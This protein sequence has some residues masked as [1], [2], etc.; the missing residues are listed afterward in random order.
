MP[1]IMVR[2]KARRMVSVQAFMSDRRMVA[3]D[4]RPDQVCAMFSP[5]QRDRSEI[6]DSAIMPCVFRKARVSGVV[7]APRFLTASQ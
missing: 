6:I 7:A 1:S 2:L 4:R 5:V 3:L